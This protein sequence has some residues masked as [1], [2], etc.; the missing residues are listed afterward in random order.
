M[1][2]VHFQ[3]TLL[4]PMLPSWETFSLEVFP[5]GAW[6]R[7][8]LY[9]GVD[10]HSDQDEVFPQLLLDRLEQAGF[11]L[12]GT[13]ELPDLL[14]Q[15]AK[16]YCPVRLT[17]DTLGSDGD[18][19]YYVALKTIHADEESEAIDFH[20]LIIPDEDR[21]HFEKFLADFGLGELKPLWRLGSFY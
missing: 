16:K 19:T 4:T 3:L 6:P 14:E 8:T 11:D 17:F 10:Y 13:A 21:T 1:G 7:A 5:M 15:A 20:D 18:Y 12:E 9:F 2:L